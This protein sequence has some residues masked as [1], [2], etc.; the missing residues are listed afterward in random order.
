[1][2]QPS[3]DSV[4]V[5]VTG[6]EAYTNGGSG[7]GNLTVRRDAFGIAS[8]TGSLDIPGSSGGTAK[9][10]VN[11]QRAWILPLWTG[12][13]TVVDQGAGLNLTTPIF[14]SINRAGSDSA[15]SSTASWF[16]V[17]AFPN[18]IRPYTVNWTVTDAG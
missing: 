12:Q 6:S 8:V 9:V 5:R 1:M 4:T 15:V 13:I 18:L 2:P 16:K 7:N 10:T 11:A 17:G 14:G 3:N